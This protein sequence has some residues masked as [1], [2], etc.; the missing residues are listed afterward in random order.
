MK[1][2]ANLLKS[3]LDIPEK[4]KEIPKKKPNSRDSQSDYQVEDSDR[5]SAGSSK[6]VS[7]FDFNSLSFFFNHKPSNSRS[8]NDSYASRVH[9]KKK[10]NE[11]SSSKESTLKRISSKDFSNLEELNENTTIITNPLDTK[12]HSKKQSN[13]ISCSK[14]LSDGGGD[15]SQEELHESPHL[16][17]EKKTKKARGTSFSGVIRPSKDEKLDQQILGTISKLGLNEEGDQQD[18]VDISVCKDLKRAKN[19]YNIEVIERIKSKALH[20]RKTSFA[21]NVTNY[22]TSAGVANT[23]NMS[24]I[25]NNSGIGAGTIQN[26]SEIRTNNNS[27]FNGYRKINK[28]PVFPMTTVQHKKDGLDANQ[29]DPF[30]D[31]SYLIFPA[32]ALDIPEPVIGTAGKIQLHETVAQS[33]EKQ[34]VVNEAEKASKKKRNL[35]TIITD[36]TIDSDNLTTFNFNYHNNS[37]STLLSGGNSNSFNNSGKTDFFSSPLRAD[38]NKLTEVLHNFNPSPTYTCLNTFHISLLL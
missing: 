10:S 20:H 8:S 7:H 37:F 28:I 33:N 13:E 11:T 19:N 24:G 6:P 5:P 29:A 32:L 31:L 18:K 1:Q 12:A 26:Q 14:Q 15:G 21:N 17:K 34:D 16:E 25:M 38:S 9:I 36:C 35:S 27:L 22:N 2:S 30:K 4:E 23:T 3:T